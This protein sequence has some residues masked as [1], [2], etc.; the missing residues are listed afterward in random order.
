MGH[1]LYG[2]RTRSRRMTRAG[3]PAVAMS[4]FVPP[5]VEPEPDPY[6]HATYWASGNY[7]FER[8]GFYRV[9]PLT[10]RTLPESI[11]LPG[12]PA[13]GL[14]LTVDFQDPWSMTWTSRQA[15][16]LIDGEVWQDWWDYELPNPSGQWVGN[17]LTADTA[18]SWP[19]P[20]G[21]AKVEVRVN[22]HANPTR[23]PDWDYYGWVHVRRYAIG[24]STLAPTP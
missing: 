13:E 3:G 6:E 1:R 10:E 4:Q 19:P 17:P 22:Y 23:P 18:D 21:N 7:G 24:I 15:R 12:G 20:S 2:G 11:T 14:D 9:D 8:L 5:P 16:I